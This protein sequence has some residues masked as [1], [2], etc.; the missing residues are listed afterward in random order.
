MQNNL[1]DLVI[2]CTIDQ[3]SD[4][5]FNA[6][7]KVVSKLNTAKTTEKRTDEAE[8]ATRK[9]VAGAFKISLPTLNR[10]TKDGTL[11]AYR[12][13]GRVLYKKAETNKALTEIPNFKHRRV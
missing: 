11:T 3:F 1:S 4:L 9:E 8:Y 2:S 5:V 6:C 13:G 10:L 7:E 12:L